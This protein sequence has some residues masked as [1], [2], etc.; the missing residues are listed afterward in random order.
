MAG[1]FDTVAA[2]WCVAR[3]A[4]LHRLMWVYT[5]DDTVTRG[6]RSRATQWIV[7]LAIIIGLFGSMGVVAADEATPEPTAIQEEVTG[8]DHSTHDHGNAGESMAR[9]CEA[10][11]LQIAPGL[12]HSN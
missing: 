2:G 5:G 8:H 9:L 4:A 1:P 12:E 3:I 10:V 6:S 11:G 7:S